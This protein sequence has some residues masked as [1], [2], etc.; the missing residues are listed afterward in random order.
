MLL[1]RVVG[2]L[3]ELLQPS[4][5]D[6]YALTFGV[7]FTY[8]KAFAGSIMDDV[9]HVLLPQRTQYAEEDFALWQLVGEL[10]FGGEVFCE[11]RV[12]HGI[13]IEVLHGELLVGRDV[14][15]DDL[16]LLK[17]QLLVCQE[18]SH[19][20]ELGALNRGQE[21]VHYDNEVMR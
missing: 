4:V 12:F 16:V 6:G 2:M 18:I 11:D 21:H 3:I 20:A 1:T 14:E 9:R 15:A 7:I 10:L 5:G 17:V 19:E 8:V 13:L